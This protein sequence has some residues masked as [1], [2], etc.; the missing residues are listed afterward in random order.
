MRLWSAAIVGPDGPNKVPGDIDDDYSLSTGSPCLDAANNQMA[1][2]D[3]CDLDRDG[4]LGELQ[5]YDLA[6]NPR[7]VDG[8]VADTG[9]GP[10]PIAH[11]G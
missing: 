1:A 5:P 4:V 3:F 10:A 6:M 2:F 7:F 8:A 9:F 11:I